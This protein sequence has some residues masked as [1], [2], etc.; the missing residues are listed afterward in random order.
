MNT[1]AEVQTQTGRVRKSS[2]ASGVEVIQRKAD[3]LVGAAEGFVGKYER[4]RGSVKADG[5]GAE[6]FAGDEHSR[7][8]LFDPMAAISRQ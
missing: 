1:G 8:R 4:R 2:W 7:E 3:C 5:A 6:V